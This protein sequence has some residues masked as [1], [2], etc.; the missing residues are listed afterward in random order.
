M[1]LDAYLGLLDYEGLQLARQDSAEARGEAKKAVA[2]T[3]KALIY[4]K[5]SLWIAGGVGLIQI[6]LTLIRY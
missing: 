2:M 1:G 6:I 3:E 4:T 5:W